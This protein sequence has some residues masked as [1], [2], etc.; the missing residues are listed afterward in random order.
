M[1]FLLTEGLKII[2]VKN[3]ILESLI[4][5][6]SQILEDTQIAACSLF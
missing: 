4:G 6:G 5:S 2:K 1:D 3:T